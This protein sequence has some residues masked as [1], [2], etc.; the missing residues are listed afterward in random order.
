[1]RKTRMIK[2]LVLLL[3]FIFSLSISGCSHKDKE[4]IVT[5]NVKAE[6]KQEKNQV[7]KYIELGNKLFEKSK[8]ADAKSAYEKAIKLDKMNKQTYL[9]IEDKYLEKNKIEDAANIIQ[10]A[11]NNNVDVDNMK[12][13]LLKLKK[14][15]KV[16]EETKKDVNVQQQKETVKPSENQPPIVNNNKVQQEVKDDNIETMKTFGI[17]T[18]VFDQGEKRAITFIKGGFFQGDEAIKEAAKDGIRL[19]KSSNYYIR[20]IDGAEYYRLS[21]SANF[22]VEKYLVNTSSTDISNVPISFDEFKA[23]EDGKKDKGFYWIYLNSQYEVVRL[24]AQYV[25]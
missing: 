10:E 15:L 16:C 19:D 11:I 21:K 2:C 3:L 25:Q 7:E 8:Y 5:E 6:A 1:M 22:Y 24:E 13:I 4:I 18:N 17:V 23:I 12:Q 9:T 14:K 20:T